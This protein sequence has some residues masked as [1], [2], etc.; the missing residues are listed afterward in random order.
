[1]LNET[2]FDL[3]IFN[4]AMAL[5]NEVLYRFFHNK[6]NLWCVYF[7]LGISIVCLFYLFFYN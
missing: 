5:L 2:L 7:S 1:M 3:A 4:L 6:I